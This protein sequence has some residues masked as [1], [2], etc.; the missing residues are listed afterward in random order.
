[1]GA[2]RP[3]KASS[4]AGISSFFENGNMSASPVW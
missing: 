4:A 1:M 3:G 2:E